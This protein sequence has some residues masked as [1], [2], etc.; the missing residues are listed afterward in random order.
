MIWWKVET[1]QI[2]KVQMFADNNILLTDI[3]VIELI[4]IRVYLI[5]E[6]MSYVFS[7]LFF[8]SYIFSFV[9]LILML[10]YVVLFG[11]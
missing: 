8:Y 5:L 7:S 9:I 1:V 6:Y 11:T 2:L 3:E 10:W 4:L